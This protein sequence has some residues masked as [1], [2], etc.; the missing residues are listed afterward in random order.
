VW[1]LICVTRVFV[2]G[3]TQSGLSS[4]ALFLRN[5]FYYGIA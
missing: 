4:I 2:F 5:A 1:F 3:G